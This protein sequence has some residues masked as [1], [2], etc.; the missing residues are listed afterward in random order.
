MARLNHR[1]TLLPAL[2]VLGIV[3]LWAAVPQMF[4]SSL[5]IEGH[6]EG[7]LPPS[8]EHIFGTDAVGRDLFARVVYG[9]R[10][11]V[12][13]ALLAVSVG[14]SVGTLL[15][16]LAGARG[17]VIDSL[18]MRGVDVLLAIPSLLLSLSIII[19]LGFG[20]FHAAIAVGLASVAFFARLVR[21]EVRRVARAD[22]VEAAYGSGGSST[23]VLLRHILPNSLTPVAAMA[24]LQFGTAILQISVLGFLGYGTPPPTPEW[25]LLIADSRNYIATAW[26]LTVLPGAVIVA[27]VLSAH[28]LSTAVGKET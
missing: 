4:T 25:G 10:A 23:Q 26:W 1:R 8:R 28:S 6:A 22:F 5:P 18:I 17:G 12:L 9:T 20:T 24:A 27:V 16:I 21:T 15:G 2:L 3:V 14:V 11:S 13:A 7:L 19:V